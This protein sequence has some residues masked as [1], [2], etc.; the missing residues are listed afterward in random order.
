M[1]SIPDWVFIDATTNEAYC[2]R[3]GKR[4]RLPLPLPWTD[5]RDWGIN[6]ASRHRGCEEPATSPHFPDRHA[7]DAEDNR[8]AGEFERRYYGLGQQVKHGGTV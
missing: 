1:K 5:F 6:F 4:E 7:P 2:E 3:C 8:R